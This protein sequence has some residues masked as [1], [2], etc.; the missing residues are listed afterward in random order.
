VLDELATDEAVDVLWPHLD[1]PHDGPVLHWLVNTDALDPRSVDPDRL[2]SGTIDVLAAALDTSGPAGLVAS[3]SDGQPDGGAG[4]LDQI[5]RLEHPRLT[6]V[7]GA[8]G[9][10]HP[11]KAVAK[12]ARKAL[13]RHN[14]RYTGALSNR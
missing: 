6:D 13:M 4:L 9:A 7:L 11:V 14:S 10:H 2:M 3:F 12:A 5:W 8:I 1:G